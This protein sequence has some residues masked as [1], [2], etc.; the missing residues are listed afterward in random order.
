M[1]LD[2]GR[3]LTGVIEFSY[4]AMKENLADGFTKPLGPENFYV[5]SNSIVGE[6][7]TE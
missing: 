1:A 7:P 4:I 5:F 3:L 2:Q 6:P